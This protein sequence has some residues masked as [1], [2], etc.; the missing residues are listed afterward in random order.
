MVD[1]LSLFAIGV[2]AF[3]AT[4]T[5]DIFVLMMFFS[6]LSFPIR[7]VVLGQYVGIGL[8]SAISVL[9]S[10]ISLVVPTYVIGLMGLV[11][12]AIGIK[13]LIE[14]RKKNNSP[15]RQAIQDKKIDHIFHFYRLLL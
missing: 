6:S 7:Q 14:I 13:N 9:G 12:I 8:L 15:S 2:T 4:N 10:L 3:A 1:L 11:P 5:D